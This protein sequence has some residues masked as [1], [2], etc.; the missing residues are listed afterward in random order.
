MTS[1]RGPIPYA[2]DTSFRAIQPNKYQM[3]L[4]PAG[5]GFGDQVQPTPAGKGRL[6]RKTH[7]PIE[8]VRRALQNISPGSDGCGGWIQRIRTARNCIGIQQPVA[9]FEIDGLRER[10]FSQRRWGPRLP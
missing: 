2:C 1:S 8:V 10:G 3:D 9:A 7:S 5:F 6:D 4:K